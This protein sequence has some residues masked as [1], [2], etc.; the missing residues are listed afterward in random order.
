[1]AVR[2]AGKR[3]GYV[4]QE[5]EPKWQRVWREMGVMD[6]SDVSDRPPYYNLVMFPYPSGDLHMG[7][8][9]NYV[10]GDL[11]SRFKRMRGY[12]VLSPFG[13][14]A[15][16][17]PAE[18]AAM[19]A[20]AHPRDWTL[21]NVVRAK[22]QLGMMGVLYDWRRELATCNPD[23]YRWTQWLFLL[24]HEG[25]LAY[26]AMAPVNWGPVAQTVRANPEVINGPSCRNPPP[27]VGNRD[28]EHGL[29]KPS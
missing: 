28:P 2:E 22:E 5:I 16:G 25:G 24:F 18:N 17:L 26:R 14:D 29:L 13:W 10:I 6:A 4:P 21:N 15:F 27:R 19:K 11:F 3:R 12:E 9:R 20:G 23:Y 7:H 1:M 8:M